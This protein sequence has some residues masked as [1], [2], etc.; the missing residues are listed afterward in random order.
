MDFEFREL[1]KEEV[2]S[3]PLFS[4]DKAGGNLRDIR[5][6][7]II[8]SKRLLCA[9]HCGRHRILLL[10][11]A[12]ISVGILTMCKNTSQPGDIRSRAKGCA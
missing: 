3:R 12:D 2:I 5:S 11:C 1:E 9:W 7:T 4:T 10:F 6:L 8:L